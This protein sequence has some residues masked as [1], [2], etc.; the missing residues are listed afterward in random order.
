MAAGIGA[1]EWQASGG[2]SCAYYGFASVLYLP[3]M[4]IAACLLVASV[5]VQPLW[6][7]VGVFVLA[8]APYPLIV[9][10]LC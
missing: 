7:R 4:Y 2:R 9:T 10:L 8:A 3:T 6:W 5:I 1:I